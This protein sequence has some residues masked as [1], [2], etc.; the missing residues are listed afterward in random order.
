MS[1]LEIWLMNGQ[2]QLLSSC[3]KTLVWQLELP[4]GMI[5]QLTRAGNKHFNTFLLC[6]L[7]SECRLR[8]AFAGPNIFFAVSQCISPYYIYKSFV[9][10]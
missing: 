8:K 6:I 3:L 4:P 5:A 10:N 2:D 7:T 1:S 9:F